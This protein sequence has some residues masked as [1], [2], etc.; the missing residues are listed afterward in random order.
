MSECIFCVS[1]EVELSSESPSSQGVQ[2]AIIIPNSN[3][4]YKSVVVFFILKFDFGFVQS[5]ISEKEKNLI[6]I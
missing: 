1:K 3:A 4:K 5:Q 2:E 6:Y